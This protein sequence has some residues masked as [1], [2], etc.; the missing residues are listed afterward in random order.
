MRRLKIPDLPKGAL[1]LDVVERP[2]G[3]SYVV[4]GTCAPS[5]HL[6]IVEKDGE[7][8]THELNLPAIAYRAV[9]D[10]RIRALTAL[11]LALCSPELSAASLPTAGTELYRW[12]FSNVYHHFGGVLEGVCWPTM[13]QIN[14]DLSQIP[15]KAVSAF[16]AVPNDAGRYTQDLSHN[17]PCA[18]Y[19][20]FLDL[21]EREGG[22]R[23]EW[24]NP[25]AMSLKDLHEQRRRK[26]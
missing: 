3:A 16:V 15:E 23:H 20:P 14:L 17:A 19:R 5:E 7:S 13:A 6:M 4:T 1:L 24:L 10:S 9:W 26:S 21:V 22:I 25:C 11:S 8:T 12:P 2:S 18:G